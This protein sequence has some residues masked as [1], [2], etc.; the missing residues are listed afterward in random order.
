MSQKNHSFGVFPVKNLW[1][2]AQGAFF[3]HLDIVNVMLDCQFTPDRVQ[4]FFLCLCLCA[5]LGV[6]G[7]WGPG[8]HTH[9]Y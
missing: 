4:L 3:L 8:V 6:T 1:K 5:P 7:S 2:S 9:T